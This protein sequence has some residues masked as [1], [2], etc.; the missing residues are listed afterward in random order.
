MKEIIRLPHFNAAAAKKER[1]ADSVQLPDSVENEMK[2]F[3]ASIAA[4]YQP[5]PFHNFEHASHVAM[6]VSKL[7]SRIVAPT[8]E[9]DGDEAVMHDHTYVSRTNVK[10]EL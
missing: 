9:N 7:L 8:E 10:A 2:Q 6:S 3:V 5:N 4:M 1:K